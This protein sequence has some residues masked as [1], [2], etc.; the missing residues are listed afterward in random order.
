MSSDTDSDVASRARVVESA[1]CPE[2]HG[3]APQLRVAIADFPTYD[4]SVSPEDFLTQCR[5]LAHL[6][7]ISG[8]SLAP[9]VA[10]RCM[11]DALSVVNDMEGQHGRLT[12][13]QITDTLTAHFSIRPTAEQAAIQLSHLVKGNMKAR[14]YGQQ[15]RRLVQRA[16]PEFFQKNGQLKRTSAS[17]HSA[18]LYRHFLVGLNQ[19]ETALLSRMKVTSFGAAIDELVREESIAG[20]GMGAPAEPWHQVHRGVHWASPLRR[21]I[22]AFHDDVD[23]HQIRIPPDSPPT[24][25][26]QRAGNRYHRRD[27]RWS[28]TRRSVSPRPRPQRTP[29]PSP[30]RAGPGTCA[31]DGPQHPR[32]GPSGQRAEAEPAG[33]AGRDRLPSCWSCG[34]RGHFKRHCPNAWL[35]GRQ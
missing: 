8:D 28:S 18:A 34:G 31:S 35:A 21:E 29:S 16:C 19:D 17:A 10:A 20:A 4:G 23:S 15:V 1:K 12:L 5:R 24:S 30:S 27:P 33:A 3:V 32:G 6:G 26:E 11:G 2:V 25:T 14:E 22:R 13:G 7:G 9:I